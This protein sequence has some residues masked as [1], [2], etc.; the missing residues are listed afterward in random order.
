MHHVH[1]GLN[2]QTV[3]AAEAS[4]N[5][6]LAV[7]APRATKEERRKVL[8][9]TVLF[10]LVL[11][12]QRARARANLAVNDTCEIIVARIFTAPS[13]RL[14]KRG[15]LTAHAINILRGFPACETAFDPENGETFRTDL[16][17]IV[18]EISSNRPKK[19]ARRKRKGSRRY[20][21]DRWTDLKISP[22]GS[23]NR[24]SFFPRV[25][26]RRGNKLA[27]FSEARRQR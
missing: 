10:L 21:V 13:E 7:V 14:R 8:G 23:L 6:L 24:T 3:Q 1:H 16:R 27:T 18:R 26:S 4:K 20:E 15:S 2:Q 11:G 19:K 12:S 9:C 25:A 17:Q 5:G 22:S